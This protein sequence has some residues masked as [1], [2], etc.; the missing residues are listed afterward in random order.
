MK[1]IT[2][3][4]LVVGSLLADYG[5][6]ENK[7][8]IIGNNHEILWNV[9]FRLRLPSYEIYI[10]KDGI[11]YLLLEARSDSF[12]YARFDIIPVAGTIEPQKVICANKI[13]GYNNYY[14]ASSPE[15]ILQVAEYQYIKIK[16]LYPGIDWIWKIEGPRVH[17]EFILSPNA[18]VEDIRLKVQWARVTLSSDQKT[19]IYNTP[20]GAL[21]EGDILIFDEAGNKISGSYQ[22]IDDS[23]ITFR[24]EHYPKNQKIII[25]P[26]LG[27]L[28][29]TYYGGNDYDNCDGS[30][31]VGA[32]TTDNAGNVLITGF[33][34][35]TNFPVYNPGGQAYFQGTIAGQID[36]F[37]AKFNN[38]GVRLWTTYYGGNADDLGLAIETNS[39][40][41]ILV[42][43]VTFS[44]NFPLYN[45]GGNAY[46]Q[47]YTAGGDAY[48]LKFDST[49][50]RLWATCYGGGL[51]DVGYA[52]T[53]DSSGAIIFAGTT[54]SSNLP[55]YNPGGNSYF[56]PTN[57]GSFDGFIVKFT[58]DGRRLWATYYGGSD[59]DQIYGIKT[60]EAGNIFLTG[61]TR[62][63]NFPVYNPGGNAYY[64]ANISGY[65]TAFILKFTGLG[66]RLWATYYGG[67]TNDYGRALAIDMTGNL[68][69]IGNT[70]SN[71]F[72]TYNPG[73][74]AYYQ[75]TLGGGDDVFILKFNNNGMRLWATYYGGTAS[76]IAR[77]IAVSNDKLY[78]TGNTLSS[79]FPVYS[80]GGGSYYQG[81]LGGVHD[82]F[83]VGFN[84]EGAREWATYYG[85][86]STDYGTGVATDNWGNIFITGFTLS[87]NFPTYNPGGNAYYQGNNGSSYD[88]MIVKFNSASAGIAENQK[89]ARITQEFSVNPYFQNRVIIKFNNEVTDEINIT[90]LNSLG[91][92]VLTKVSNPSELLILDGSPISELKVGIY[93]LK[94]ETKKKI[95]FIKKLIKIS[96]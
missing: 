75:G 60:D 23:L 34:K 7:G 32:I 25:D 37:I 29:A 30:R 72:P 31:E 11:S 50:R 81:T 76:D 2:I 96:R 26:P 12:H 49:G 9:L 51:S 48:L 47:G 70:S 59:D 94:M 82:A 62:S 42:T 56:Q 3:F 95:L 17:N 65:R 16:D 33:T 84:T 14:L 57:A 46:Y 35:S 89:L 54:F 18:Q 71:N 15:G 67:N 63:T 43:G 55:V 52:L 1:K 90:L 13:P 74:N 79:N 91:E 58:N 39:T 21:K 10:K 85:G 64:Q 27:R 41:Q 92:I 69:V 66:E 40:N 73:G 88:A 80:P 44:S 19:L 20:A 77:S 36:I 5:F 61:M 53:T 38:N 78:I 22:L 86:S 4:F 24:L 83:V 45:P 6:E 28:W 87:S 68:Y 8:Q 93:F